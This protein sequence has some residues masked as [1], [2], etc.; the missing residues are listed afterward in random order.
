MARNG[1][2]APEARPQFH[3]LLATSLRTAGETSHSSFTIAGTAVC[4]THY[5]SI[6]KLDN[7]RI[8]VNA[9]MMSPADIVDV[10]VRTFD[11][12]ETWMYL[13]D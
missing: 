10:P 13:D 6:E 2:T 4:L 12:A 11:G 5:E 9:R 3:V 1:P 7:S 8:A